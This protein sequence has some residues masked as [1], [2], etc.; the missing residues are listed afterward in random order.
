MESQWKVWEQP[1]TRDVTK[2]IATM[3]ENESP[4]SKSYQKILKK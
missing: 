3:S 1:T 4:K 2:V